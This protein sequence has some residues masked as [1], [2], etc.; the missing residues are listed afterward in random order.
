MRGESNWGGGGCEE[1]HGQGGGGVDGRVGVGGVSKI[2]I[3]ITDQTTSGKSLNTCPNQRLNT[4]VQL[5]N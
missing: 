2:D 5:S 3:E 1:V 4:G